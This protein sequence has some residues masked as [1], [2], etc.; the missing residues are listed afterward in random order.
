MEKKNSY[1][2][3]CCECQIKQTVKF[4]VNF[5]I[6]HS[7]SM[8]EISRIQILKLFVYLSVQS[9]SAKRLNSLA[10]KR[11]LIKQDLSFLELIWAV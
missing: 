7:D 8:Q 11:V 6:L 4:G 9:K 10:L 2:S 3:G 5:A 1:L